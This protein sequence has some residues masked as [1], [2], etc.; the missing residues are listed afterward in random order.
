MPVLLLL[1]LLVSV[2]CSHSSNPFISFMPS[3]CLSYWILIVIVF[4]SG[5]LF[6]WLLRSGDVQ[7]Q[8]TEEISAS[9][10]WSVVKMHCIM[11]EFHISQASRWHKVTHFY[12]WWYFHKQHLRI[13]TQRQT[14]GLD[15]LPQAAGSW[16]FSILYRA[17]TFTKKNQDWT[18]TPSLLKWICYVSHC[19]VNS[20]WLRSLTLMTN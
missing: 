18:R 19:S 12:Y 13:Y 14:H 6:L 9:W 20:W 17:V 3:L 11:W 15:G 10:Y 4:L 7:H 8:A 2:L 1:Y 16:I 5:K